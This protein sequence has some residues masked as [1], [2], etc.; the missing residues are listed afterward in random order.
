MK[1]NFNDQELH[2]ILDSFIFVNHMDPQ[3]E[4]T[5]GIFGIKKV[6]CSWYENNKC[7]AYDDCTRGYWAINCPTICTNWKMDYI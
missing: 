6:A 4:N 3:F 7:M 2:S 1:L 5:I